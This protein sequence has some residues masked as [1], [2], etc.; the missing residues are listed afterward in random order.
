MLFRS[1][2]GVIQEVSLVLKGANPGALIDFSLAHADGADDEVYAYLIGD[3]YTELMHNDEGIVVEYDDPEED[4][5]MYEDY[6]DGEEMLHADESEDTEKKGEKEETVAEI[7]DTLTPKQKE[8]VYAIITALEN[9]KSKS[10]TDDK[11]EEAKE[12]KHA[13]SAEED[14]EIGR[15]HV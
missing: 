5:D 1:L 7:F 13:D 12:I 6:D 11:K 8:A 15:A 2:H 14:K 4:E 9:E 3:E 10:G